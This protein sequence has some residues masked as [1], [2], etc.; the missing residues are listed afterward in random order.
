MTKRRKTSI[1]PGADEPEPAPIAPKRK[2]PAPGG[3]PE[4]AP[5][6][7]VSVPAAAPVQPPKPRTRPGAAERWGKIPRNVFEG[8][9]LDALLGEGSMGAVFRAEQLSLHRPVAIKVLAPR[10]VHNE[11]FLRRFLREARA[12]AKLN[13]PNVVSGI[14]VGESRGFHFFLMEDVEGPTLRDVIDR[15][16][17]LEPLAAARVVQQ[18]ARA[19]EHAHRHKL[20]HRD[21][22]AGTVTSTRKAGR[23]S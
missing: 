11:S 16:G 6:P 9:R 4:I 10:L 19:L 23:N 7:G 22:K 15:D 21:V 20:M 14:D 3:E 1:T 5:I 18:V 8:Y 12:V 2:G 17:M 13:H